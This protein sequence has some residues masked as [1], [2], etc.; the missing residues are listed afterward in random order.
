MNGA[1][2]QWRAPSMSPAATRAR[3]RVE[4]T[5]SPS[6]STSGTTRV[7]NSA[8]ARQH[9]RVALR[10][11]AE[12]EVLADRDLASAPSRSIRTCSMKS[13]A[14]RLGELLVEGDHDQLL[15]PEAVDHVALDREGHDQLRQRR[16][17]QDLERVRV[18]GE[19][20]V[21][22]VDHRLVAEVD[23]VEG[24]DRDVAR[25]RLGVGQRGDLDAHRSAS[26]TAGTSSPTRSSLE[27]ARRR[28]RPGRGR[29]RCG[30][31]PRSR[32][33][34]GSRPGCGRRSRP[35]T[36]SR[37]GRGRSPLASSSARWTSTS[38]SGVSTISP[39]WAFL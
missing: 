29:P 14:L 39:R 32:R 37:S 17:V 38:R 10:L 1:P 13:S 34:R 25:A 8:R 22:V 30:A 2:R 35:S 23:A 26:P 16:R 31:A 21:G 15:D 24:A 9:L 4:E 5:V 3:I 27:L 19:H 20:G 33:R 11:G 36:R 28:P 18:E 6:T 12:A 7:S